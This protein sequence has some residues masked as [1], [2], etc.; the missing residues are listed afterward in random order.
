MQAV[1]AA[2]GGEGPVARQPEAR[3]DLMLIKETRRLHTDR[4][5]NA[6]QTRIQ[7]L[8]KAR[9]MQGSCGLVGKCCL[10]LLLFCLSAGAAVRVPALFADGMVVQREMR[11]PVWGWATPGERVSVTLGER[12]AN[13]ITNPDGAWMVR[14]EPLP[15]GGPHTLTVSGS[16][17]I[18]IRDVLVGEV[19][20]CSGQSWMGWEV[21]RVRDAQQETANANFP[22][23]RMFNTRIATSPT[24]LRDCEGKWAVCSPQTVGAFSGC[25]YFFARDLH[26]K[27][28]VPV[29]MIHS[30]VPGTVAQA[31]TDRESFKDSPTL[32][33]EMGDPDNW[34][35]G[36][37]PQNKAMVLYNGMIAPLIPYGI[38]GVIWFQGTGGEPLKAM[39]RGWRR[40]WGQGDPSTGSGQAFPFLFVQLPNYNGGSNAPQGT[41]LAA[42]R[43]A[44]ATALALPNTAM[45]VTI[46]IGDPTDLHPI[47]MQ[48]FG[49]RLALIA[50]GTVYGQNVVY[51]GPV[52]DH[53]AAEGAGLRL[54]FRSQD[55]KLAVRGNGPV[56]GFFL[57]GPNERY[58]PANAAID[59]LTVVVSHPSVLKPTYVRYAW[60]N[61]PVCNLCN[62]AGLPARP[63]R[64]YVPGDGRAY[65]LD[66]ITHAF[67]NPGFEESDP[68]TTNAAG[69]VPANG[70][71]RT[72]EKASAGRWSMRLSGPA[73]VAQNGI[74]PVSPAP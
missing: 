51:S 66:R 60:M 2:D 29:G 6:Q 22:Q 32:S 55:G 73:A 1:P 71:M 28:K 40:N 9:A 38:K 56:E 68:N 42:I 12:Q 21:N 48:D 18:T 13:A 16:N 64:A 10:L 24:P 49:Q 70:A 23:I 57:A 69:W 26:Q 58:V 31:W 63:F 27:L 52:Y 3:Y 59:G 35:Y 4:L 39:I 30:S 50:E 8:G 65:A 47:N 36:S 43:E 46:D 11:I 5:W 20:V 25:G 7:A 44:Q 15:A 62:G 37:N 72:D 67:T 19:W 17:T 45:A 41:D 34:C 54:H 74:V 14:L 33:M 61:S 53:L